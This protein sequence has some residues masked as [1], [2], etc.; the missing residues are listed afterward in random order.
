MHKPNPDKLNEAIVD[1]GF[2]PI[3]PPTSLRAPG[4]LYHVSSDG[5]YYSMLCEVE[6]QR[7]VAVTRTSFTNKQVSSELRKARLGV[8]TELLRNIETTV[9]A[10][11]VESVK[12][13]LDDVEVLEVSL[14]DLAVIANEL[15]HRGTCDQEVR[16]YLQ[17]GDYIC[18]G[19]QVLKATTKYTVAFDDTATGLLNRTAEVIKLTFDADARFEGGQII[20][21]KNLYY[22][23]KL[24]PRC[25][26]LPGQRSRRPPLSF[27]HRITDRFPVLDF[28]N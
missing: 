12:L 19:Q 15:L 24:A 7:L 17:E 27:W 21:G 9:N 22:G 10:K 13:E 4:S 18:Q 8:T 1:I 26:Y 6:P 20:S 14:E 16:R 23:M 2:Y 25:L 11:L 28:R 5:K 3:T